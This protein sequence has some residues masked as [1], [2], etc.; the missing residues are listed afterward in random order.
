MFTGRAVILSSLAA[1]ALAGTSQ[2]E[3]VNLQGFET[4]TSGWYLDTG[5]STPGGITRVASGTTAASGGIESG[6]VP[7]K[8]Y[9][10]NYYAVVQNALDA[11]SNSQPQPFPPGYGTGGYSVFGFDPAVA[12]PFLGAPM[13]QSIAIY[14]DPSTKGPSDGY[15]AGYWI[16]SS[17]SSSNP[18]DGGTG[19]GAEHN[20]RMYY[21]LDGSTVAVKVDGGTDPIATITRA[22]WYDF[23][24]EYTTD[25]V[26]TDLVQTVMTVLD[27]NGV[28]VGSTT[29]LPSTSDGTQLH[30][31][32]LAGPGYI[33]LPVWANGFSGNQLAIDNVEAD[34][35]AA[36]PEP[37]TFLLLGTALLAGFAAIFKRR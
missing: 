17:P 1:L 20:F 27:S 23:Q 37:S 8:A 30:N 3:V 18:A 34:V 6:G 9:Q 32:D 19:F 33:W 11:Y 4:D 10:G 7:I 21:S 15:D 5:G 16:D 14:I 2:A 13:T 31:A 22:G 26:A 35:A 28:V 24:F 25:G 12:P 36:T 29:S